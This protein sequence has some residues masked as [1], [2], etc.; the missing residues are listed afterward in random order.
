MPTVNEIS[1]MNM[2]TEMDPGFETVLKITVGN[3]SIMV[4]IRKSE[5]F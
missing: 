2:Q 1:V 3:S 5:L 4:L